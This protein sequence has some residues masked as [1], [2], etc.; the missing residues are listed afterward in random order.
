MKTIDLR[1]D[2][3]TLPT[4]AMRE[5]MA[6]A[7]LGDDV[8]GEDPTINA[9][10][11]RSAELFE[12]RAALFVPSGTMGNLASI[13][14]H[15]QRGDEVIMGNKAHT[16]LYEA[17]GISAL[18]GIHTYTI[19][20]QEDGS[21]LLDDIANAIRPDDIHAPISRLLVLENTQN[22]CGGTV[23]T[24]EYTRQ[25]AEIAHQH[26]LLV[27][28]DGAR[29]FNA[30]VAQ[31]VPVSELTREADSVTFCLSKGLCCPAGSVIVGSQP[32]IDQVRRVRK[33]LGGGMRQA[34]VLAA[35]G[36]V[37]LDEMIDRLADDHT[38]ARHLA[39]ALGQIKGIHI[40][41]DPPPTNMV[42][43]R[44]DSDITLTDEKL[45]AGCAA[46]GIVIRGRN[47]VFRLV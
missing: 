14:A 27:H 1:S 31:K 30:A 13:L 15:C 7:P 40:L 3:V 24:P 34:G 11:Q 37:A 19:P 42:Y 46:Q 21:L 10:E 43:M 38:R 33:M 8:Y 20:N 22:A 44:L 26:G 32:F 41:N 23:L 2:T 28:I 45:I 17:G 5:A 29:I 18:G 25:A 47:G 4:P 12:K 39:Q 36:L 16:F 9:L 6:H 35:A